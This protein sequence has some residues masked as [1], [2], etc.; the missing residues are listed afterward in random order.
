MSMPPG[1]A[2]WQRPPPQTVT[3]TP[4][5]GTDRAGYSRASCVSLA[6]TISPVE[7]T[8]IA[9]LTVEAFNAKLTCY[10]APCRLWKPRY[11]G[12]E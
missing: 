2:G 12:L 11:A 4:R 8:A 3:S 5:S 6:A 1:P 10:I 7:L 9:T